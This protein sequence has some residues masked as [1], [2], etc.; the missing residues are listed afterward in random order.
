M[1][2]GRIGA[3][4]SSN[5]VDVESA[6][7]FGVRLFLPDSPHEPVPTLLVSGEPRLLALDS[8]RVTAWEE[9]APEAQLLERAFGVDPGSAARE[10]ESLDTAA[11]RAG[12]L[13]GWS[14]ERVFACSTASWMASAASSSAAS[15][16]PLSFTP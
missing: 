14:R 16:V 6:R 8:A 11:E 5:P 2:R 7:R 12:A 15:V 13:R 9:L 4:P 1:D 3:P 10:T